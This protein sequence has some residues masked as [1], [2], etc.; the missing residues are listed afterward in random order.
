MDEIA[1]IAE[2]DLMTQALTL[3][4][5]V[6]LYSDLSEKIKIKLLEGFVS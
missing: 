1:N 3:N 4:I 2:R 5:N 6:F